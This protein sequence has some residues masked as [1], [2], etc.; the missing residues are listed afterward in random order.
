MIF[1]MAFSQEVKE[2]GGTRTRVFEQKFTLPSGVRAEK[3]TS[4]FGKDGV[5]TITAPRGTATV[6]SVTNTSLN[7]SN[8]AIE[9]RM[10]RVLSPSN[11]DDNFQRRDSAS[12]GNAV[13]HSSSQQQVGAKY[14]RKFP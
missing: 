9:Q 3:V 5:L 10:D 1:I 11:W 6:P 7:N 14:Q 13:N 12:L 2:A 4:A 8:Q